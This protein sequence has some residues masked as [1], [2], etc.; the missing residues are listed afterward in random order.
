MKSKQIITSI[1]ILG[2]LLAGCKKEA[3]RNQSPDNAATEKTFSI[4][5]SNWGEVE[6]KPIVLYTLMAP[7]GFTVSISNYGATVVSLLTPDKN[8]ALGDVVLGFGYLDGYLQESNPYFGC[9]VGRYANRIAK[10]RFQLNG[11]SY[12]LSV[13]N[14]G[15]TLHGGLKGFDK[16]VWQ[17][18]PIK[19]DSSASLTLALLSPDGEEGFPGNLAASVTYSI[20]NNFGLKIEYLAQ[21]DQ[22]TPVS[23]THHS[24]FNLSAGQDKDILG[25]ELQLFASRYTP[26]DAQ[27]I[28]T[29][30]IEPVRGGPM[31]FTQF[32]KIGKDIGKVPGGYDHNFVLDKQNQRLTLAARLRHTGS[33]RILDMYTT[34]PAVQFYSGNFLNGTLTGKGNA[35]YVKH[36]GLCL[37]AQRYPDSPNQPA[38]PNA[39]LLPGQR[40]TQTTI[41]RFSA[42]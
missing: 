12:Q 24:Y 33:G 20:D 25:H 17:G 29:G 23:F 21:T 10:G 40:Y 9:T 19:T 42:E 36:Y 5:E 31:D 41:Y 26:V 3:A 13:N 22:P 1:S 37:E 4:L 2:I 28:P 7:N 11:K 30:A 18:T 35:A 27:L 39:I 8:G 14:N 32:K 16:R 34:E 38:F 15:N 6:G